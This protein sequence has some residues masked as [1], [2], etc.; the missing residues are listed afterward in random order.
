M[1]NEN[2][3]LQNLQNPFLLNQRDPNIDPGLN[4]LIQ[5]NLLDIQNGQL[6]Q[7]INNQI[8]SPFLPNNSSPYL[9]NQSDNILEKEKEEENLNEETSNNKENDLENKKSPKASKRRSKTEIEGRTFECK[10]CNKRYLSYPALYTHCKQ[11]HNTNNSS[12]RGRGRPKKEGLELETEKNKFN[13]VNHTYFSKEERTGKTEPTEIN[14]CVD[15]AFSE[16]Y[17]ESHK[18]RNELRAM[19]S[20][21]S[22]DQH[23]FLNKF[24]N[25]IHD[26]NKNMLNEHEITDKVLIYYLNKMSQFCNPTY[27]T[28]LIKF[29]T[30]FREHVNNFN[31]EKVDEI[32]NGIRK[33]YTEINNAEDVPDSS[34]EFITDFLEPDTKN[35]DFGFSKEESIELTQNLCYW[36]YDNN[37][38]CSKLSL[39]HPEK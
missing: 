27:F 22:V 12:G 31:I 9:N 7:D 11:K 32:E 16:I 23:P 14:N 10:L 21:N 36:M 2:E 5:N 17:S 18:S 8:L 15:E 26:I 29:V 38:T 35:E 39:I 33:E 13:P 4:G 25:D 28:K 19:K 6:S 20:Y 37:F 30:L 3:A 34:N 1:D 24:K